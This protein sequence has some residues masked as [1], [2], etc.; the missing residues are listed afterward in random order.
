MG[1]R[2]TSIATVLI[3]L[4]ASPGYSQT[5]IGD[6]NVPVFRVQAWGYIV[7]DFSTGVAS[8]MELRSTL[9]KGLST[10]VVTAYP[11]EIPCA[12]ECKK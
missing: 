1:L 2:R 10:L 4:L 5:T 12:I 7:A 3:V 6:R 11:A 8:Y 9:E